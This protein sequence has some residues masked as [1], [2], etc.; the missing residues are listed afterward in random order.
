MLAPILHDIAM[1]V[2]D[3]AHCIS[4][5]GHDFRPYYRLIERVIP[6]LPRS[7][8]LL[9]TTA[10]ANTRVMQDLELILGPG[11]QVQRGKLAR[12][13]LVLQNI[14][15]GK[16]PERM[17]WLAEQLPQMPGSGILYTMTVRDARMLAAWLQHCGIAAEAYYA[18]SRRREALEGK[19]L[20]NKLKV[21]VATTALGM[22]FD[23]P[24]LAFVIHYQ[25]P[26]SLVAYYQQVGR[27]G[28][29]LDAAYGILLY[30]EGD[31]GI[32]DFFI[33]HAFPT[34][35]EVEA[36]LQ[37][38]AQYPQGLS[39]EELC[40]LM[41]LPVGQFE[42]ALALLSLEEPAPLVRQGARWI[43][44]ATRVPDSFHQR[45][46]RLTGLRYAERDQM[47]AYT[48][49][50]QGQMSY[51]LRALD[52]RETCSQSSLLPKLPETASPE[53]V[54]LA[55]RFCQEYKAN[56]GR[57]R[58]GYRSR[59]GEARMPEAGPR[60]GPKRRRRMKDFWLPRQ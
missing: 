28:R 46:R 20:Q 51:L 37:I 58:Q 59:S 22:G 11:L 25:M 36:I 40:Q 3:E 8:R 21:L 23:K 54:M 53:L 2:I 60:R 6:L 9:A 15:L 18:A 5:W 16:R 31:V 12:S 30:G 27:A 56:Q 10:T 13:S 42:K 34:P 14:E 45:A 50:R 48:R 49:L 17:A 32:V 33:R 43:S 1:L 29:A 38:L 39:E 19:L 35:E 24:D 44:T 26:G 47:L 41:E 4:D 52:S 55:R 57:L 7:M